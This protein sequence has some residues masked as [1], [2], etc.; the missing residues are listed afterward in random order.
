MWPIFFNANIISPG[1]NSRTHQTKTWPHPSNDPPPLLPPP[2]PRPAPSCS[3]GSPRVAGSAR[4]Q[5]TRRSG[6]PGGSTHSAPGR[7]RTTRTKTTTKI[8]KKGTGINAKAK[9]TNLRA[10]RII[11]FSLLRRRSDRCRLKAAS[12]FEWCGNSGQAQAVLAVDTS[13][14]DGEG[15]HQTFSYPNIGNLK[16]RK[17]LQQPQ[18]LKKLEEQTKLQI[19]EPSRSNFSKGSSNSRK[20]HSIYY[21]LPE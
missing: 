12:V 20:T 6:T 13:S 1:Y 2:S 21:L 3:P 15:R 16:L 4:A 18:L 17:K 19:I 14:A 5:G 9:T 8:R 10:K 7:R 11:L